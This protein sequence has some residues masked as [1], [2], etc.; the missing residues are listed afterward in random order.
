LPQR[1]AQKTVENFKGSLNMKTIQSVI[2]QELTWSQQSLFKNEFELRWGGELVATLRFPKMIGTMGEAQC[3][4]GRWTFERKGFWKTT[5]L[6]KASES[7]QVVGSYTNKK[8]GAGGTIEL[9]A[10]KKL[11]IWRSIWKGLSELRTEEGEPLYQIRQKS[12]LRLSASVRISRKALALPE[13]PWLVL[14]G[15]YLLVM[16]RSDAATHAAT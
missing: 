5:I 3:G 12:S 2:D 13:L 4:D 8:W 16:A 9:S 10:G 6:V 1:I 14:F 15:F 11:I 7:D